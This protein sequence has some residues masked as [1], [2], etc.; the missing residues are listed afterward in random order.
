MRRKIAAAL[1][2]AGV[3]AGFTAPAA[4]AAKPFHFCNSGTGNGSEGLQFHDCDPG[5]SGG[6]NNAGD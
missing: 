1:A 3:V 6:N 5:N 4:M 2:V